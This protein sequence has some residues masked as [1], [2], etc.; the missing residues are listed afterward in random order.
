MRA[1]ASSS[2]GWRTKRSAV[3][4]GRSR[5]PRA[6]PAPPMWSSP[7]HADGHELQRLVEHVQRRVSDRP[8]ERER[9]ASPDAGDRRPDRRLGRPVHVPELEV[10]VEQLVGEGGGSA[11]PPQSTLRPGYAA[12]AR[13][14]EH[15]PRRR[16][17]LHD[18]RTRTLDQRGQP[19][20]LGRR[21]LRRD[22]DACARSRAAGRARGRRCRRRASSR[23][24][25]RRLRSCPGRSLIVARKLTSARWG[26]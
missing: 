15:P 22:H 3:S 5:Y 7:A 6:R 11:S 13:V 21:L 2:N 19:A 26:I 18:G 12:P 24:R 9:L 10:A 8:A 1:D 23:R 25:A 17:R 20:R 16:R 4:S 14:D